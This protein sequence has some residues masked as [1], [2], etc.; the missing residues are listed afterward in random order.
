[1]TRTE[2]AAHPPTDGYADEPPTARHFA[3]VPAAGSGT[4]LGAD[5]PKQ[6]LVV[7][8]ARPGLSPPVTLLE[9][10]V[11][12]LMD[13]SP[14]VKVVVVVA[15]DDTVAA[16]LPGLQDAARV[17]VVPQGGATRRDSVR[18][19]LDALVSLCGAA[20]HDWVWVHDAARP[21]IDPEVLGR[22][23]AALHD[24]PVGALLALPVADTVKRQSAA[25]DGLPRAAE[26]VPREAL[27]Q[28]QTPQVFRLGVLRAALDAHALV[29]DEA[30]A[31]EAMGLSPRL[32]SG[33]RTNFK[34]TT[35]DDWLAL[36]GA[37]EHDGPRW[38]IGQGWDVHALVPGRALVLGGVTIPHD[39]GLLGHSDADV[40]L[41]AITDALLGAA[42]LGDIGR[43]F[44]DTDARFA[45]AD[46][47]ALLREAHQRVRASGWEP[48][49]VDATIVAQ[50]PRLA[51]H[52][53]A[54]VNHLAADLGL[55]PGQVN[56]K[57]KTSER[58]GFAGR[59]EGIEAHAVVM[60][61]STQA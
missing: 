5:R 27:W 8:S 14:C 49:N 17:R 13:G 53:D 28:A 3:V 23:A 24:E 60:I 18:A 32:V 22:L 38:R 40:L 58:L 45:G 46:S 42:A 41:H 56:V 44:P 48:V 57:A 36:Q 20:E 6:Y 25:Q 12:R 21:G 50:A 29:T 54:M 26:T 34:V 33:S 9:R 35:M 47:R 52:I 61:A 15:P 43:H 10:T 11:R 4:R 39:R 59:G 2:R 31:V 37:R 19:G 16:G 30:S 1:M 55:A 7:Q 51:P